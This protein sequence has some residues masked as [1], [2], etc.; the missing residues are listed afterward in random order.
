MHPPSPCLSAHLCRNA[1]VEVA[2]LF[3]GIIATEATMNYVTSISFLIAKAVD[4]NPTRSDENSHS[5][6]TRLSGRVYRS[7]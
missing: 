5:I 2:P 7:T 4:Y 6:R 3:R 1:P